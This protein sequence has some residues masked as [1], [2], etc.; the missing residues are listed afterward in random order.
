MVV[1]T[2]TPSG[3][4]RGASGA[5]RGVRGLSVVLVLVLGACGMHVPGMGRPGPGSENGPPGEVP[6]GDVPGEG[7]VMGG[8]PI[9][10]RDGQGGHPPPGLPVAIER[11]MD[12]IVSGEISAPEGSE[13]E[14]VMVE[15]VE[16]PKHV[17]R[18]VSVSVN[19]SYSVSYSSSAVK[20][21]ELA[22]RFIVSEMA[23]PYV[24]HL[25]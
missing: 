19:Q 7:A 10:P 22:V 18:R 6:V 8:L 12:G 16:A 24:R 9:P 4:P 21:S 13:F 23:T 2:M 11:A 14:S 15:L 1:T 3:A 5:G 17:L 25:G 20:C